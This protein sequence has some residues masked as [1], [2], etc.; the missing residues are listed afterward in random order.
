M[1]QPNKW[2]WRR[3]PRNMAI[4]WACY[5]RAR[6]AVA[7]H[8]RRLAAYVCAD[9]GDFAHQFGDRLG[10]DAIYRTRAA[11]AANPTQQ[12]NAKPYKGLGHHI[13][14]SIYDPLK[15]LPSGAAGG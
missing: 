6:G 14:S 8:P 5:C 12:P 3:P 2:D 4:A 10:G 1:C 15:N 7:Q 9:G 13:L 11:I